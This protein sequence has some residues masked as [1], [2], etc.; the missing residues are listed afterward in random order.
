MTADMWNGMP[1]MAHSGAARAGMANLTKTAAFEWA[2][3]GVRVNAVAPGWI[4]LP[5]GVAAHEHLAHLAAQVLR[6][7]GVRV[8]DGLVLADQAAQLVAE[9]PGAGLEGG[10]GQ[11]L[12]GRGGGEGWRS[13]Q[14][15]KGQ[16]DRPHRSFS[17]SGR[18]VRS[19]SRGC[20]G[21]TWR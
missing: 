2:A 5:V 9:C 21:P 13:Q 16:D 4:D 15:Q 6:E 18:M 1:G 20:S 3:S 11:H 10:V 17:S 8:G 7:V 12:V 14:H 19:T